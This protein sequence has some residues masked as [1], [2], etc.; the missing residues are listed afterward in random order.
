[1]EEIATIIS[2]YSGRERKSVEEALSSNGHWHPDWTG[3]NQWF[4]PCIRNGVKT[5]GCEECVAG[6]L[7]RNPSRAE[8]L[9][10]AYH[11][12]GILAW[13]ELSK[14]QRER[15]TTPTGDVIMSPATGEIPSILV[16]SRELFS[17]ITAKQGN[18]EHPLVR[19]FRGLSKFKRRSNCPE[20]DRGLWDLRDGVGIVPLS[21]VSWG[22]ID[23][24]VL[25]IPLDNAERV[26][27]QTDSEYLFRSVRPY[28]DGEIGIGATLKGMFRSLVSG[29][30]RKRMVRHACAF[31][32]NSVARSQS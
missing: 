4:C 16:A 31:A 28:F 17:K 29:E 11:Y 32:A 21:L 12:D 7:D 13:R 30:E 24:I 14:E 27:E 8:L 18:A 20:V 9:A 23:N 2:S 5:V 3:S 26:L 1:M 22:P 19:R 6:R 15:V 10:S 25:G